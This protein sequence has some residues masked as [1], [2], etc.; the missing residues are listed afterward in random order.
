[1]LL[2]AESGAVKAKNTGDFSLLMRALQGSP[3]IA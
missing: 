1:M 3:S 2:G